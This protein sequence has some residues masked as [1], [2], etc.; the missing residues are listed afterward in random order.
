MPHIG[1]GAPPRRTVT[2]ECPNQLA[3]TKPNMVKH[4]SSNIYEAKRD[5][6]ED[7][8]PQAAM[9]GASYRQQH[10]LSTLGGCVTNGEFRVFFV[11]DAADSARAELFRYQVDSASE[12]T[13]PDCHL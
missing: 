7:A 3:F 9:A 2:G 4:L 1:Q 5:G 12:K 11:F 6:F 8:V 13:C 10:N